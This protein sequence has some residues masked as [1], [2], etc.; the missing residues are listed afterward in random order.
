MP[1]EKPDLPQPAAATPDVPNTSPPSPGVTPPVDTSFDTSPLP[2]ANPAEVNLAGPDRFAESSTDQTM[3]DPAAYGASSANGDVSSRLD[4]S[5]SS[6]FPLQT[7]ANNTGAYMEQPS[8]SH[9]WILIA[10]SALIL[11]V[12]LG[13]A[14]W[15]FFW[16]DAS[17]EGPTVQEPV[18]TPD[19]EPEV[20]EVEVDGIETEDATPTVTGT[21]D[22]PEATVTV[23]VDGEEYEAEL[24]VDGTWSVEITQELAAGTYNVTATA[25]NGVLQGQNDSSS[26]LVIV[27]AQPEPEPEPEPEPV[28]EPEPEPEAIPTTGP[29][30]LPTTGPA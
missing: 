16:S 27:A 17:S 19:S 12:A 24:A 5:Q 4:Q 10:L 6:S 25:D 7:G 20:I 15:Y 30:Q 29:E 3:G 26:E 23:L 11:L 8:Q 21:V 18:A 1:E 9:K 14:G 22:D 28:P 2:A 13:G